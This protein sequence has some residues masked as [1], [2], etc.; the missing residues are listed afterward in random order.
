MENNVTVSKVLNSL[1]VV[2]KATFP[3]RDTI[4]HGY[5]HFEALTTNDYSYSCV[6]CGY[7]PPVVVMD[8]HKKGVFN[9]PDDVSCGTHCEDITKCDKV[10]PCQASWK[11]PTHPAQEQLIGNACFELIEIIAQSKLCQHGDTQLYATHSQLYLMMLPSETP[12]VFLCGN[13]GTSCWLNLSQS[14]HPGPWKETTGLEMEGFPRQLY[15]NDCGIFMLMYAFYTILDAPYD[16]T[17]T[18]MPAL[19]K[20]WCVML[21]GNF[22]LGSHGKM[23][24]HWME[25]SKALLRGEVPPV[26]RVRKRKLD[27]ITEKEEQL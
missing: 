3:A 18:D 11:L 5:M 13:L 16:F 1:E 27:D 10:G 15:G 6:C 26:F 8:L 19:R 9:L 4:L 12:S 24:A 17:I 7:Y 23:F 20:W 14:I 21:M 2:R 22:D 25:K